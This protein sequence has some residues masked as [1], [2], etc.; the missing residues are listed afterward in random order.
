MEIGKRLQ[1]TTTLK[2]AGPCNQRRTTSKKRLRAVKKTSECTELVV[3]I[4]KKLFYICLWH[5]RLAVALARID[6][7]IPPRVEE[8]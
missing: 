8:S 5:W 4:F 1:C 2:H 6:R 7:A 3:V